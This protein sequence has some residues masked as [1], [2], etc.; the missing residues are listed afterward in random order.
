[1]RSTSKT[2]ILVAAALTFLTLTTAPVFA[3]E[4]VVTDQG[5]NDP[6]QYTEAPK[7]PHGGYTTTTNKCKD[8]HAVHIATGA[9]MLTRAN[10]RADTCKF[11]HDIGS[12]GIGTDVS[13]NE[14]GHG[15]DSTQTAQSEIAAPDDTAPQYKVTTD[16]W[17]CLECHSVHDNQ[18][19]KLA[20][21]ASTKLLKK[22]PNPTGKTYLYY[23]PSLI[24]TA[25]KETTQTVSH[26]CSA[27][28]NANFGSHTDTKQVVLDSTT[29]T[30]YGHDSSGQGYTTGGDGFAIVNPKD[31]VNNGPTCKQCHPADGG[32]FPHSGSKA[33][34]LKSS[35]DPDAKLD[36]VC[37]SCHNTSSLQ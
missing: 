7:G 21:Y 23:N 19:V 37:M 30:V 20:N 3:V 5:Y 18:T 28:H 24:D 29:Q 27:C 31:G 4:P 8:C 2:F 36:A 22:D 12:P 32:K 11:C 14:N 15:L 33:S 34:M 1:M 9:Y 6:Q 25:T 13:L 35:A 10:E 26:W 17:G 16:K